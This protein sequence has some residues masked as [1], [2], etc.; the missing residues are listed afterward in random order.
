[1][2]VMALVIEAVEHAGE[3]W[4]VGG[5]GSGSSFKTGEGQTEHHEKAESERSNKENSKPK[6]AAQQ[7]NLFFQKP[8][9][10]RCGTSYEELSP[11]HY[12]FNSQ[13]GWCETCEG[14]G[15][16]RGAPAAS[17]IK[18]PE[19]SLLKG[20]IAGWSS[21]DARTPFGRSLTALCRHLGVEP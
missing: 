3:G 21:I 6:N 15:V 11:H 9:S 18:Y 10:T 13:M 1:N 2:G 8:A 5:Q 12:S 7:E 14:L 17:I 19:K 16:Q 20:A 4:G